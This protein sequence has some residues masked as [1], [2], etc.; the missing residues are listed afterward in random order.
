MLFR[1]GMA[2]AARALEQAAAAGAVPDLRAAAIVLETLGRG[3]FADFA[4]RAEA[5]LARFG[6]ADQA[7]FSA[8]T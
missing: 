4:L 7:T 1:S 6:R 3:H 2:E 5:E 8:K